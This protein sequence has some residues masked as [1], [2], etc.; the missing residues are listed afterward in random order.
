MFHNGYQVGAA[1][2]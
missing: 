2:S 1:N